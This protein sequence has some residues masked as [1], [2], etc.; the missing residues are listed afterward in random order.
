MR[1]YHRGEWRRANPE[2]NLEDPSQR[3][4]ASCLKFLVFPTLSASPD[5]PTEA[6]LE[7]CLPCAIYYP[8]INGFPNTSWGWHHEDDIAARWGALL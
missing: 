8:R 6:T 7:G 4:R 2:I 1:G 5:C 3:A